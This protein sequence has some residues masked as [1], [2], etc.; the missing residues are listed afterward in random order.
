MRLAIALLACCAAHAQ[1]A[2]FSIEQVLSAPFP[3]ELTAGPRGFA[4][5]SDARGVRNVMYAAAPQFQAR[6]LTAYSAD[7]GQE[8]GGLAFTPD[9]GSILYVRGGEL[10]PAHSPHGVEQAIWVVPT[11]GGAPRRIGQG[12]SPAVSPKGGRVAFV[13]NNQIWWAPLDGSKPAARAFESRGGA[14]GPVWSP[15][16]ARLAFT[17]GRGDHSLIGVYT[18]GADSLAYLDPSTD[19]DESPVWSPDSRSVA[20]LR[21]PSDGLRSIRVARRAG[22]PWSIR[23]ADAATGAG[24]ELWKAR[25]GAGSFFRAVVS[26]A[27]L[28]WTANGRLIFPWEGDGW[29]HLYSMPAAGGAAA[30]LTPGAFEVEDVAMNGDAVVYS[31]NQNDIDRRHIWTV[32]ALGGAP[33]AL[34]SGEGIETHP[35]VSGGTIASLRSDARR[36]LH[37]A[38]GDRD[39]ETLPAEFPLGRMVTPRQVIFPSAD[40]LPIHGQL[41]LPPNAPAKAPA[42]V[43]FHGGSRRQMLLGWHP[44]YYY[45]NAYALNQY[46]ANAGYIVLSVNYRSGI[47]YGLDFREALHYG[48]SGGSE[49][50]DVQGAG[51]YLRSLPNV[52]PQ[53]IGTWGGSYG[54][55]LV[56]VA[57]ARASDLFRAGVDFHGVHDWAKEIHIPPG[58]PDYKVAFESSPMAFLDTWRSP[59]LLM[60]GDADPDVQFNQTVMLYDALRRR[61]V[62]VE[63]RIFP[64]E[65]HDFLL[66]RTWTEAYS[67]TVDFFRRKLK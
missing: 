45:S 60:Q 15:D 51:V 5:V 4:W 58:E 64:D 40:G 6:A 57:L 19:Y 55:Y 3:T 39:L 30:L 9:G 17:S 2:P 23:V 49:Y 10:N 31:S 21:E 38:I 28:H 56:A 14:S 54:G 47:G 41:F 61:Q 26:N 53:R 43:F 50:N 52:D 67:L 35:A 16:G 44:M 46:F 7:D 42:L 32:S 22:E 12:D 20:F 62:D 27:Q 34:T 36:P 25:E 13:R 24:H 29:T 48:P 11:S 65:S 1:Q 33:R 18:V 8:I 66:W 37:V 59:V 63:R